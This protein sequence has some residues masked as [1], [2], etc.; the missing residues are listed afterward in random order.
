MNHY[1]LL[2]GG[3][4]AP[5]LAMYAGTDVVELDPKNFPKEVL[6]SDSVWIVEFYAP[7]CGHC[8]RLVPDYTKAAKA[9]KGVVKVGSVNADEHR[10]L[11]TQYGVQGFPTIKIFGLN[12]NKP[13]DYNGGRDTKGFVD[14]GLAAAKKM[15]NAQLGG[16]SGGG[17]GGGSGG[18]SNSGA[19]TGE[20]KDVIE[21]TEA[22]F[23]KKVFN[24]DKGFLVEFYAPW[25]GHC[26]TLAPHWA[27]AA[28][29]LKGKM[30]LGALDAT[31]HG[32]IAQEYGVQG[33]PTIK[34]WAPGS[35]EPEEYNGGRTAGDI[36]KWAEE[37]FAE[38]I[39]PPEV[40][41]AVS[42]AAVTGACE[43]HPLCVIAF[44]PH[45][46]DC[47]SACRNSFIKDLTKLGDKYKK[48]D[49]GWIWSEGMAQPD[50]ENAVEVGGFGY[51]AMVVLSQKKMK[52]TTLTGSFGYDGINEF[53]RDLSYGKS[54]RT[55]PVKGAKMPKI[56]QIDA[57]DGKDG[58]LPEE[59]DIDLSDVDLD[60][61]D[62]L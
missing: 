17:G 33:Y 50:L 14:A 51:P 20:G 6:K 37:R 48:K 21:L 19:G 18:G 55:N 47:Q 10:S 11:G 13:E 29:E 41:Q 62:E 36:V 57:W 43:N 46:L 24:S 44:L 16:K 49:W 23:R 4:L 27:N 26:K 42:E 30:S 61:H 54:G 59:E 28:T 2:L 56:A 9:L 32:S 22:N 53:L 38:N 5:S 58:E 7:W 40:V 31:A 1:L 8:Q 25:C 3:L 39:P 35:N 34:Y 45:I 52:Y 60:D 15:V 12:K